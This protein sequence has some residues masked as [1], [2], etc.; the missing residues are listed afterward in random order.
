[1]QVQD[2]KIL[3]EIPET[4]VPELLLSMEVGTQDSGYFVPLIRA[5]STRAAMSQISK[6][7]GKTKL[8]TSKQVDGGIIIWRTA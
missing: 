2:L 5:A 6:Y 3:R 4:E 7:S 1:M 8:F